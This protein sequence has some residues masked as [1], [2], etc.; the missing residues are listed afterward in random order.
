M[1]H[2]SLGITTERTDIESPA[3]LE[4]EL[5]DVLADADNDLVDAL[6]FHTGG[7]HKDWNNDGCPECG[8]H[9]LSVMEPRELIY[10]IENNEWEFVE[11]GDVTGP[12]LSVF[13]INCDTHLKDHVA[14]DLLPYY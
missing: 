11:Q 13:C 7:E 5:R 4:A 2:T 14:S 12:T 10:H 8:S 1:P 6:S 9:R 3:D